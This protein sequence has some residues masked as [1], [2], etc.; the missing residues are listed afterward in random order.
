MRAKLR[1]FAV[2]VVLLAA[3]VAPVAAACVRAG[4]DAGAAMGCC[5][6]ET[7]CD[8]AALHSACC[9]CSP[10]APSSIPHGA[11]QLSP[12]QAMVIAPAG[13]VEVLA[14]PGRLRLD[15]QDA[16]AAAMRHAVPEPPWLLNASLL[17]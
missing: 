17:I 8:K 6:D 5:E 9:P 3:L 13:P 11:P 16:Y 7:P 14:H 4:D 15:A 12:T 10:Q 2:L 1:A